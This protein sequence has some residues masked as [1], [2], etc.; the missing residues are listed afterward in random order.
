MRRKLSATI[1]CGLVVAT[2]K[3]AAA[4][5]IL[6]TPEV[7]RGS[8]ESKACPVINVGKKPVTIGVEIIRE[9]GAPFM[10]HLNCTL[11]AGQ[12]DRGCNVSDFGIGGNYWRFTVVKGSTT[13]IQAAIDL[14]TGGT[15][16][17]VIPAR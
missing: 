8:G 12:A 11:Q 4:A 15:S 5:V 13:N 17:L 16:R 7:Y 2:A 6:T 9:D 3:L 14:S 10:S 1:A